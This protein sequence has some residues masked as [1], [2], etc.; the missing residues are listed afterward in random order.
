MDVLVIACPQCLR[1][2]PLT[3]AAPV[4]CCGYRLTLGPT[5]PVLQEQ[6][7]WDEAQRRAGG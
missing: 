7:D 2:W 1:L 5:G 6:R 4:G 3:A